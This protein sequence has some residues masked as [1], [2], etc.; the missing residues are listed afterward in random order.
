MCRQEVCKNNMKKR[1]LFQALKV[2][3]D[4]SIMVPVSQH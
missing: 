2:E 3:N 1:E 4:K